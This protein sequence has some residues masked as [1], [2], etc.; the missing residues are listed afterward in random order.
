[1]NNITI[2]YQIFIFDDR[3][4]LNPLSFMLGFV[5]QLRKLVNTLMNADGVEPFLN[6]IINFSD[7]I[8]TFF[9]LRLDKTI[10]LVKY[11]A[12]L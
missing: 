11:N 6:T 9:K 7:I 2:R 10:F 12:V 1:M 5:T 4:P 8:N 3:F